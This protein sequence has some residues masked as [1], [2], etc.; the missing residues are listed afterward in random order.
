MSQKTRAMICML[1]S[2]ISFALMAV[3][4]RLAGNVP[5]VEKVFVRNI[6]ALLIAAVIAFR[7]H[8][9]L[10]GS[11]KSLP[12]LL[13]RSAFG[14]LGVMAYFYSI[15]RMTLADASMLNRLSPFFLLLIGAWVLRERLT[16]VQV[17]GMILVFAASLMVIKPRFDPEVIP[18]LIG[19]AGALFAGGA[20][21]MVRLLRTREQ[22]AT[23]VFFF[24][25]FTALV[26]L[27][28]VLAHPYMPTTTEWWGLVGVG[29]FAAG[30]QFG[31]TLAYKYEQAS[32]VSIYTY[33]QI[34]FSAILGFAL[35]SEVPDLLSTTGGILIIVIS[36]FVFLYN[37]QHRVIHPQN[38]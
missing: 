25:A 11:R 1:A 7:Q 28:F 23:I 3:M 32:E 33:S 19:T 8:A 5:V 31:L 24:A 21:A 26:M 35:F 16:R 15:D 22:P 30:G 13:G 38:R 18:A 6:V 27:P 34:L 17:P 4:V 9:P 2:S 10:L 36:G 29:V 14:V 20:Y 37:R 12:L